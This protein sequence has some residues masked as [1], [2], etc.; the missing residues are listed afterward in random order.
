MSS[1]TARWVVSFDP[2]SMR[3]DVW[4]A[5]LALCRS[6]A[7][8]PIARSDFVDGGLVQV[9][10]TVSVPARLARR[11]DADA[12]LGVALPREAHSPT[13]PFL[14]IP[15]MPGLGAARHGDC[16]PTSSTTAGGPGHCH[17]DPVELYVTRTR[18]RYASA[19]TLSPRESGG[20]SQGGGEQA[21]GAACEDKWV[22]A[23]NALP[24]HS[25]REQCCSS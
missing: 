14:G 18:L 1:A 12:A 9:R 11:A 16:C 22:G 4:T 2:D 20:G 19:S 21:P 6:L 23:V 25:A 5:A 3:G 17:V 10:S 24:T 7:G 8:D 13:S 15:G